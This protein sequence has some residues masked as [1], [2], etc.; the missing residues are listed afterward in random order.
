MGK[1]VQRYVNQV[2]AHTQEIP[3][4]QVPTFSELNA[5]IDS[6]GDLVKKYASLL[7]A[8]LLWQLEPVIQGD[9]KAPFRQ[10]WIRAESDA[11]TDRTS[12]KRP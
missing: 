6:I 9:W 2:V 7:K 12:G 3:S 11:S 8:E 5:A 4:H 1:V 10:P